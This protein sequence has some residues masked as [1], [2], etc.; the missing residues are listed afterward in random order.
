[1]VAVTERMLEAES[2]RERAHEKV[3]KRSGGRLKEVKRAG[4]VTPVAEVASDMMQRRE[5]RET[6]ERGERRSAR[7]LEKKEERVA[8]SR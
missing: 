7:A 6:E 8:N 5:E 3:G 1:M 2:W 4:P